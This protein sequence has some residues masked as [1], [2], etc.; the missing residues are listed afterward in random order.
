MKQKKGKLPK[1]SDG[2]HFL[3]HIRIYLGCDWPT[4]KNLCRD[5]GIE[6]RKSD[7]KYLLTDVESALKD[8]NE[9]IDANRDLKREKTLAEIQKLKTSEEKAKLE[10]DILRGEYHAQRECVGSLGIIF[11]T[12]WNEIQSLP[13][14]AQTAYP[15]IK[16][17][18]KTITDIVN[19][20]AEKLKDYFTQKTGKELDVK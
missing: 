17:I 2:Y 8:K 19:V 13:A 16:G 20:S 4:I 3:K 6:K 12:V 18:D 1:S 11:S 5:K 10:N 15:E 7:G 14:R 9:S